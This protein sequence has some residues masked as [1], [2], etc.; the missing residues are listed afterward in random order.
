MNKRVNLTILLVITLIILFGC[1]TPIDE[2]I[3]TQIVYQIVEITVTPAPTDIPSTP[4]LESPEE[5][6]A[7]KDSGQRLGH[8]R[9]WDVALGDLD[10][11]GDLDAF[12]ANGSQGGESNAVWLN[13]G[14]GVYSIKEQHLGFGMG[15][16]LG[17]LDGDSDLDAFVTD[18]YAPAKIWLNKGDGIFRDSE[19]AL[20]NSEAVATTLG[21]LDDD[22]DLDAYLARDGANSVWL[23][24]G[25]G[26]FSDTGQRLGEEITDDVD[27]GDLDGDGDLDIL[28]GGWD[29]HARVWLNDGDAAFADSGQKLTSKYLHIHGLEIG[30]LDGDLDLDVF[31]AVA[32]DANQIWLNDGEGIFRQM[33]QSIHSSPDNEVALGDLDG[34]GDL[35]AFIAIAFTGDQIWLNDG[36]GVFTTDGLRLGTQYSSQVQMGDLDGDGDLDAFIAHA[37]LSLHSGG[38]M[39]NTVWLNETSTIASPAEFVDTGGIEVPESEIERWA[40]LAEKDDYSD[41]PG[42]QNLPVDYINVDQLKQLL[43]EN[44]WDESHILDLREFS[45]DDIEQSLQWLAEN[46]DDVDTVLFY[47]TGHDT[48]LNDFLEWGNL[49]PHRWAE[50]PSNSRILIVDTCRAA[51]FTQLIDDDPRP[52][53]S[54]A[55]VAEDEFAWSGLEEEGLPIIGSVFVHYFVAAFSDLRADADDNG[56]ISVQEAVQ[57]AE[58]EQRNYM[59]DVVFKVPELIDIYHQHGAYPDQDPDFPHVILDDAIGESVYLSASQDIPIIGK[60]MLRQKDDMQMV[61]VPQ[62]DFQMGSSLEEIDAAIALCREHYNICNRWY[63]MREDPQHRVTLN[64]FWIDQTEVTNAQYRLC[65]ESGV[66]LPPLECK[67]GESTYHDQDKD[68]HPVVCVSWQDAQDYCEWVDARLPTEAEWE[69]A[70]RGESGVIYP[71]GDEFDGLKLNYCDTNCEASHADDRYDD[72]YE[73]S[74][75]VMSFPDGVSWSY[76]WGMSGNVSEWVADWLGDYSSQAESNLTGPDTGSEKLVKGCSWFFHPA[77]CRG[78]TRASISTDTRYDY[79][80]FR[81]ANSATE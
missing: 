43:L 13:D 42:E 36:S 64:S 50:I 61:Y 79:L 75:P 17:D 20:N 18:W 53:I 77:Y 39:P 7:F 46:A 29:E 76:A 27:V 4:T 47:I 21:D 41:I 70:F 32:G 3:E 66:C 78:A 73:K 14:Q 37:D 35:D 24:D 12:V 11:D 71:W 81:C 48:Y 15:V 9:S 22:G 59:H 34:D 52:H 58:I 56:M 69:Y 23:N 25:S 5:V 49:F 67:K 40:V 33:E 68:D 19:Q 26:N 38:E 44:G 31:M 6:V 1:S 28:A 10:G 60:T 2:N 80:G 45:K 30:D 62:G 16:T 74:S 54:I 72:G 55:V 8:G 57:M 65:V 63:Y 51:T